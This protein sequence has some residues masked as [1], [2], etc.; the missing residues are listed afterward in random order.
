MESCY[1]LFLLFCFSM[2]FVIKLLFH[3][4]PKLPPSPF[5]LPVIGH[6]H[7]LKEPL[8]QSL[9]TL[10][11][12]HGPILFLK[13][14]CHPAIVV[15]SPSA[16]EECFTK[17][18]IL[19]ANRPKS[20]AAYHLTYNYT[21]FVWAPYGH[22]WR[23]LRRFTV[24][25]IFSSRS[26]HRSSAIR[27]EEVRCLLRQLFKASA[28]GTRK[29]ELKFLL[30]LLTTNVV[31]RMAAGKRCVEEDVA[32]TEMGKRLFQEFK[33]VFPPVLMMNVCDFVPMLRLIGYK[34]IE[35]S[36]IKLKEK[37]DKFL[38]DLLDYVRLKRANPCLKAA[39][40]SSEEFKS[41][42]EILLSLQD[43]EPE[44]YTEEVI[45]STILILFVAGTET[46]TSTLE[47]AMSLLL[48]HP[49]TLQK[50]QKEIDNYVGHERL[51]DDTDL[52]K[53]PYLRCVIKE[54][55]RLYPPAPMLLPH[56]ASEI[57]TVGGYEIPQG[58]MLLVNAWAVHRD[59]KVWDEPHD[60]KPERFEA[61]AVE[62]EGFKFLPFGIGRRACPGSNMAMR[63]V[64]LALGSLIQ[65]FQWEKVKLEED[66]TI[67]SLRPI[68]SKAKPLEALCTP[69]QNLIKILSHM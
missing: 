59:P 28:A 62:Q 41:L 32:N 34:G 39:E 22:L 16:I 10:S 25:E 6:L 48:N 63:M 53:L 24:I 18:D 55:L 56:S 33:D 17:N 67:S 54:T 43:S 8:Y 50:V 69:R 35:K 37:R 47:W 12:K 19:F 46:S 58:T 45:K 4:N 44:F 51:L 31:M 21:A 15:S 52:V 27:G 57:S 65:C 40:S 23:D 9:R 38:Q 20:M 3:R 49:E 1:Y 61:F 13:F 66:M 7:L 36:M 14:G 5:S 68:F 64:S 42:T 11:S 30:S 26:L 60:F 2:F 29:V